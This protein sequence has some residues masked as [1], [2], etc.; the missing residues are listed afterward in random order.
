MA[1]KKIEELNE[2]EV[3]NGGGS[4][5]LKPF[6][7]FVKIQ[8]TT[9]LLFHKWD[10]EVVKAKNEA[11]KGSEEKKTEDPE[12][13]I[14]RNSDGMVCLPGRYLLRAIVEAARF[15]HDPRSPRKMA[16][17]L[18]QAG[19]A[20]NEILSPMLV[21]GQPTKDWDYLDR[22]RVIIQRSAIT[23]TRPAFQK[24]WEA[25]L[26]FDSLL[27]DYIT[28]EFL[29]KLVD[30]AGRFIGLADFRPTYGRFVVT[31]WETK[32]Y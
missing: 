3:T 13:Y 30:D 6:T 31:N 19:L 27:P 9:D 24:G 28:P 7:A 32:K 20:V 2:G 29:R 12:T 11:R 22:Q 21:D 18:V 26:S 16:K 4:V 10:N 14:Y 25:E 15:H 5:I 23:R 8:G 1:K 17:E